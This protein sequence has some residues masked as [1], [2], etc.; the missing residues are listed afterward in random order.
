MQECVKVV[1]KVGHS[2]SFIPHCT[3]IPQ[4]NIS[5]IYYYFNHYP[6]TGD[7]NNEQETILLKKRGGEILL[8]LLLGT[9]AKEKIK[10]QIFT[11]KEH[12]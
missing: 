4:I 11:V 2:R 7:T 9:Q 5:Q 6:K 1:S 3:F 8:L 12:E 10:K